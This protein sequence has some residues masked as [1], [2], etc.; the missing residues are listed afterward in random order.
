[1]NTQRLVMLLDMSEVDRAKGMWPTKQMR[2][3]GGIQIG[4]L[5]Q[6]ITQ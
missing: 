3:L 5:P 1:M 4:V 2:F 6:E